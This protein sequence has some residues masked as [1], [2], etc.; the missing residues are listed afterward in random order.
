MRNLF[1]TT[2]L[3]AM[4]L[5][6]AAFAQTAATAGTDLNLRSG[7]GV[8]HEVIGVITNGDEVSVTGCIESAN[9]CE[10]SY[11]DQTG[12][13]YGDYLT[14]NVGEEIQPLYPHRAQIG[15]AVIE[16]PADATQAADTAVSGAAG[17]AAGALIA[18]PIGAVAG[19][20][21]GGATGATISEPAPEIRTYVV[22]NPVDPV[23][24]DGEV[25]VGA[26]LPENVTLYEV[27]GYADYRY[28]T[29][30]GQTVLVGPT[31]RRIVYIYR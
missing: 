1:A 15:V 5:S 17:A 13:A 28:V 29:V 23:Y 26:G 24:L 20:A 31:D 12:W 3:A 11:N 9:W 6:G 25:V 2:A 10:V 21:L 30:N 14:A 8:Q 18:G 16:P 27:P 7:P 4:T 19:A 22:E